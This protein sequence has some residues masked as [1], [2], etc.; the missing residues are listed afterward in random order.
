MGR[1]P[2][3]RATP[4]PSRPGSLPQPCGSAREDARAAN[5]L[6]FRRCRRNLPAALRR[7]GGPDRSDPRHRDAHAAGGRR[8]TR[9]GRHRFGRGTRSLARRRRGRRP[10]HAYRHRDRAHRGPG[11]TDFAVPSRDGIE[12]RAVAKTMYEEDKIKGADGK[13]CW[14]GKRYAGTV[15][16]K[17]KCVPVKESSI[18]Q[19]LNHLDEGWKEKLGAAALAGSM[20]LGAGAAHSRVTPDGQGG[21]TGGL[22][23]SAT[24]TAPADKPAAE[25]PNGFSKEYLQKA[26][27]PNRTGRYMISVE[28]AQELLKS[29][30]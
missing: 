12:P 15:N 17:D 13:A 16:G 6:F 28:K 10:A 4:L 29:M 2:S 11:A 5:C 9:V 25:A 18:L 20:A 26:A 8:R 27:D 23:P 21:F 22:K 30:P 19:G 14:K 7:A 24:V 3:G 1:R